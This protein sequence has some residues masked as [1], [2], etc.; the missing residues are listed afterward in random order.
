MADHHQQCVLHDP[1]EIAALEL[2]RGLA[3]H[4]KHR[5]EVGDSM[6]GQSSSPQ[7]E[8]DRLEDFDGDDIVDDD[9]NEYDDEGEACDFLKVSL[10]KMLWRRLDFGFLL[11]GFCF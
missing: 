8:N 10:G 5:G 11:M 6:V 2:T 9:E 7:E 3:A 4:L 1:Q